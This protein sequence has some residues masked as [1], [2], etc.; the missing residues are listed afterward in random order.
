MLRDVKSFSEY[1]FIDLLSNLSSKNLMSSFKLNFH[2][3]AFRDSRKETN[4]KPIAL[5]T[6]E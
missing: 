5:D 2:E 3:N 1:F 4:Y 6:I